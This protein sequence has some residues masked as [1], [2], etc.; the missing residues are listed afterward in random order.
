ME[1]LRS[2]P[3]KEYNAYKSPNLV[4]D[5][6]EAFKKWVK[7]NAK[8]L[9]KARKSNKLSY[10]VKDNLK[11]VSKIAGWRERKP[12]KQLS[13][14]EQILAAA[15]E[16]HDARTD[17]QIND[18]LRR[19]DE[20]QYSEA[21]RNNFKT[22]EK[23]FNTKR[24]VSMNFE[25]ANNGKGNI[26]YNKGKE[27]KV[28][29]QSSVVAHEL[30][31]RGFDVTAQPNWKMGDDPQ[32]L[33][34]ETWKCWKNADGTPFERPEPF[35]YKI[36]LSGNVVG[37]PYKEVIQQIAAHTQEVG[38]Y[39]ISFTWKGQKY[40]H[41]VT[42]ERKADG[43]ILWYDP[44]TGKRNFFDKEYAKKIKY[45]RAY[46]VDNLLFDA[47]NWNVVRPTADRGLMTERPKGQKSNGEPYWGG[48]NN[49]GKVPKYK[50]KLDDLLA[51]NK[52]PIPQSRL[53]NAIKS[54]NEFYKFEKEYKMCKVAMQNGHKIEMLEEVSG[55][56]S[57]DILFDGLK[58]ELKS[59]TN[60]SNIHIHANKAFNKQGAECLLFEFKMYDSK[61]EN[62]ILKLSNKG[63]HGYYYVNGENILHRF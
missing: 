17:K 57:C 12:T 27:F 22:I 10:F 29:C 30:R 8:K 26:D 16:R 19:W 35:A 36:S 56:S 59:I 11:A 46:R 38:R 34:R 48:V 39:H 9:N 14:R 3:E 2:L 51:D 31:M 53:N 23:R 54:K 41:I 5:V 52:L 33:S 1:K 7:T 45:V 21:Q 13:K 25:A 40:G 60:A 47:D 37:I 62:E 4:K 63:M 32:L 42:L 61:F 15:K 6:P 55:V 49:I 43:T 24:G 44:Q 20:R 50:E 58:C 28:N 18:I